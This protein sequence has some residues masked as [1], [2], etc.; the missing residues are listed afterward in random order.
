M[1][2]R[3]K[4]R[5]SFKHIDSFFSRMTKKEFLYYLDRYAKEGAE[6][7]SAATPVDTGKT[8]AS[9]GYQIY[10]EKNTSKVV[11]TNDNM[12]ESGFPI[13]LLIQYGHATVEGS[14]IQ[15]YDIINQAIRPIFD[16]MV[17]NA[18]KEVTKK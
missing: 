9:W 4:H 15:G 7:L 1:G 18:W 3:I 10:H 12:N 16:K 6:A 11:W 2:F 17:E 13:V 14:Y 5:G 8:A